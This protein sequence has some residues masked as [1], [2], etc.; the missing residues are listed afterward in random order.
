M[1]RSKP[2]DQERKE[3]MIRQ[4]GKQV[5]EE[6]YKFLDENWNPKKMR[7]GTLNTMIVTQKK[8]YKEVDTTKPEESK[9]KKTSRQG[10]STG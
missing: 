4:N 7:N 1:G 5:E 2:H 9:F 8:Q 6:R 10:V 3:L